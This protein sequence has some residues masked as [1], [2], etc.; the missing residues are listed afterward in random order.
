MLAPDSPQWPGLASQAVK[1]ETSPVHTETP[2]HGDFITMQ[3]GR[4]A[5]LGMLWTGLLRE[6]GSSSPGPGH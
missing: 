2:S 1:P 3:V 5:L 6:T 4:W